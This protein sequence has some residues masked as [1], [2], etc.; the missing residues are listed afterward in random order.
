MVQT[1]KNDNTGLLKQLQ[2]MLTNHPERMHSKLNV[3]LINAK[4]N[5]L[6]ARDEFEIYT[7]HPV[8]KITEK[9]RK[10]KTEGGVYTLNLKELVE[11]S[12]GEFVLILSV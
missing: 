6:L 7:N 4:D 9:V 5:V 3:S 10:L 1:K 8:D 12:E 2:N 11:K